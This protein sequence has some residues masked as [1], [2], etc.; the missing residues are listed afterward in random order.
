MDKYVAKTFPDY[1]RYRVNGVGQPRQTG[2][3]MK[4]VFAEKKLN[5][6]FS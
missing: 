3:K 4:S 6:I 5:V 1:A 2:L